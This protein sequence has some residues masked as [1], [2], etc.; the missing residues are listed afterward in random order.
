MILA[1]D[2]ND[3]AMM[4]DFEVTTDDFSSAGTASSKIKKNTT[5]NRH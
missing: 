2:N 5:S 4:K 1:R 3:V